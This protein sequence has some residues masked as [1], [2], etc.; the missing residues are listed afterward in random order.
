MA[1]FGSDISANKKEFK[2]KAF[3]MQSA[4]TEDQPRYEIQ[5]DHTGSLDTQL[6]LYCEIPRETCVLHLLSDY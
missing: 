3:R 6:Y 5:R 1:V 4:C 2:N